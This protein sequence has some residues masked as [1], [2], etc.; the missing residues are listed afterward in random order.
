[1]TH[2]LCTANAVKQLCEY[3]TAPF[4]PHDAL[5]C[6]SCAVAT[7]V[8]AVTDRFAEYLRERHGGTPGLNFRLETIPLGVD[9]DR[10][11]PARPEERAAIRGVLRLAD[12]E[13]AVLYVGRL[14]HHAKAHPFPMFRGVSEAALRPAGRS[15]HLLLPAGLHTRRSATPSLE[16]A[17]VFA[18][19]VT[20]LAPDGRDPRTRF[21]VWHAADLFVSPS[22]NIQETFGLAVLEAMASGLPVVASDWDGYRDLVVRRRDRLPGADRDGQ[23]RRR[24]QRPRGS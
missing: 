1:M 9:I 8:R 7:M 2:T 15:V 17:R 24:Q 6:T 10:F 19:G 4:E 18:P 22:D 20:D 5:I 23:G 13:V 21:D 14:S 11:R 3:V 16:G 12:D